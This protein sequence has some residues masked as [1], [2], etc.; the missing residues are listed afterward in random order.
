LLTIG[1]LAIKIVFVLLA[2]RLLRSPLQTALQLGFVLSQGSEFAFVIFGMPGVRAT[3]GPETSVLLI[4][5]VAA[6]LALTPTLS[7]FGQ[8]LARRIANRN[9]EAQTH[10]EPA[11]VEYCAPVVVIGMGE[12]GRRVVDGLEAHSIAYTAIEMDHD[13]FVQANADGYPVAF[14]DAGDLRLQET[15]RLGE[16]PAVVVTIPRYEVS[17]ALTPIMQERYPR[18]TRYVSVS[19]E[20]EK[21]R[22]EALGMQAFVTRSVPHGLELAAA[23]LRDHG[24]DGDHVAAWMRQEQEQALEAEEETPAT[25]TLI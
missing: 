2:A 11:S 5:A 22:F 13:R 14:G 3:L 4:T 9:L 19:T 16:R 24:I 21:P 23:V 20:N 15:L 6:S 8:N 12:V 7:N 18:L 10:I 17:E 1:F 25:A